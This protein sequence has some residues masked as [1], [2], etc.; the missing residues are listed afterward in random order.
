MNSLVARFRK[1]CLAH[2]P[3]LEPLEPEFFSAFQQMRCSAWSNGR[4]D[5]G[6]KELFIADKNEIMI[7]WE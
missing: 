5:E 3:R 6:S 2:S 7:T 1:T 4:F